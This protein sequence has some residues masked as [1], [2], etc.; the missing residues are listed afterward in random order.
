MV[1]CCRALHAFCCTIRSPSPWDFSKKKY[2]VVVIWPRVPGE[3]KCGDSDTALL[4]QFETFY[5]I[6]DMIIA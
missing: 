5:L 1:S 3:V 4:S 6:Y 2:F